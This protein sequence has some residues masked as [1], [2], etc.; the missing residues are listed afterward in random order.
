MEVND[1][2]WEERLVKTKLRLWQGIVLRRLVVVVVLIGCWLV[3]GS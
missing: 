1:G 2:G 3:V